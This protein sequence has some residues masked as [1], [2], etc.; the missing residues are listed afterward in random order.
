MTDLRPW[1]PGR[2]SVSSS[3]LLDLIEPGI[4]SFHS[5]DPRRVMD[6]TAVTSA[7]ADLA[8]RPG[9]TVGTLSDVYHRRATTGVRV[10]VD[11]D[12][13]GACLL[14]DSLTQ[15]GIP[16]SFFL[17]HTAGYA[18]WQQPHGWERHVCMAPAYE[19]L[20]AAGEVGVHLD[21]WGL[22]DTHAVDGPA[23]VADEL[24]WLRSLGLQIEGV[25]AHN[26]APVHDR[27][28]FEVFRE[29]QI[30]S[31][32][33]VRE[34]SHPLPVGAL[35]ARDLGLTWCAGRP[36]AGR[37]PNA[38]TWLSTPPP[39]DP[40][41]SEAW[42][43]HQLHSGEYCHWRD[44]VDIWLLGD[45][46]WAVSDRPRDRWL[47]DVP[48]CDVVALLDTRS[49]DEARTE[50]TIVSLHPLYIGW[51]NRSELRSEVTCLT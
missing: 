9:V 11:V 8:A 26:A 42:L 25:S 14:A 20:A 24:S 37:G 12:L 36:E 46:R 28:N 32:Q 10:D 16:A 3:E 49:A 45:D 39:A 27:E 33:L 5:H 44:D 47:F 17:L 18:G 1:S 2:S 13:V 19:A 50:S 4:T 43:W 35:S 15:A 48:W 40:L 30:D 21:P 7:L 6:G 29:W 34:R 23:A 51:P 31:P 41:R 22:V 38:S